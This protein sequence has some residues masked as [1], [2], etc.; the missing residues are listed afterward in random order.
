LIGKGRRRSTLVALAV[1]ALAVLVSTTRDARGAQSLH[2]H[3]AWTSRRHEAVAVRIERRY[4]PTLAP[5]TR[6]MVFPGRPGDREIVVRYARR[7]NGKVSER[8]VMSRIVRRERPRIELVGI[9]EADAFQRIARR[10][11]DTTIGLERKAL[12]MVATAY[13]ASCYGCSGITSSG[14]PA[15]HGIV[16]VD[17]AVIPLGTRLYIP[18][19]GRAVAGD[20][21][22][23]IVGS[24]ID[25]GFNSL[26]DALQFGRRA[27]IVY[28]LR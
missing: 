6:R 23:D 14:Q 7:P 18:G 10:G 4:D 3:D 9:S 13:T 24:R 25:L 19:Y 1:L 26:S 15:G 27:I 11:F 16:A 20:T 17:P 21:G 8:V 28:I 22:G 12:Q 5:G 2:E